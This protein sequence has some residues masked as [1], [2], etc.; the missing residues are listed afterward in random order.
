MIGRCT[1]RVQSIVNDRKPYARSA[2]H[3]LRRCR[4]FHIFLWSNMNVFD[5][6]FQLIICCCC[7]SL[8][9]FSWANT[10]NIY[11]KHFANS[12]QIT[13]I[14]LHLICFLFKRILF[15]LSE[16][17]FFSSPHN[18]LSFI[19]LA[20][21]VLHSLYLRNAVIKIIIFY[22]SINYDINTFYFININ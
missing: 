15:L 8:I 11:F 14:S 18:F 22:Q 7:L 16:D 2:E 12:N 21:I 6:H 3:D 10:A 9:F 1:L 13:F 5:V 4:D 19:V 17:H 20:F